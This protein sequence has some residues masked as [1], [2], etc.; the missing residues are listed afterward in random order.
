[1]YAPET[2]I[3]DTK[4]F[5]FCAVYLQELIW[6]IWLFPLIPGVLVSFSQALSWK[7]GMGFIENSLIWIICLSIVSASI[8]LIKISV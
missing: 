1:M 2:D 5:L 6:E 3:Y 7:R 4:A 8:V